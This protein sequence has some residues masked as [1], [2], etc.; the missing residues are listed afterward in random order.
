[1][2]LIVCVSSYYNN[3]VVSIAYYYSDTTS[4]FSLCII[5]IARWV[6]LSPQ[7]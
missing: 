2:H 4:I 5:K 6:I 1:M 7:N 3:F